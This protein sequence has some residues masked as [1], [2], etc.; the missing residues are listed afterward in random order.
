MYLENI[1]CRKGGNNVNTREMINAALDLAGLKEDTVD[2]EIANTGENIKSVLAGIDVDNAVI[3]AAKMKGYD[4]VAE[5]HGIMGRCVNI[6]KQMHYDHMMRM[7]DFGVPINVA[8]KL[9]DERAPRE[10][11]TLHAKNLNNKADFAKFMEI[12]Y[13]GIHTPA[14]L[15]GQKIVQDRIDKLCQGNS[16]VKV[17]DVIDSLLEIREYKEAVAKPIV[18]VGSPESYA[19]RVCVLFA[20][21]TNAGADVFQAYFDA[22]VGTLILMH[23]PDADAKVIQQQGKGNIILAGHMASDSIGFNKILEA[24]EKAGIAVT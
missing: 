9:M 6:G 19:G 15:I 13:V 7:Y 21:C 8:Q 1:N 10:N 16:F 3:L 23:I 20:G 22:G 2:T 18:R 17:Q 12:P 4:C 11:F 14:D 24:W 5:H